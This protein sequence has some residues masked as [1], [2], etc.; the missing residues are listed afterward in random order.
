MELTRS[1][2]EREAEAYAR[3]APLYPV[4]RERVETLPDAFRAGEFG[5][6]DAEWVVRWYYRRSPGSVPDDERRRRERR[7]RRNEAETL[8][9]TVDAVVAT[10]DARERVASLTDLDGVDVPVASAFL[11]FLDPGTS[12]VVGP[13]EWNV[14]RDAGFLDGPYPDPPPVPAYVAYLEAARTLTDRFE[15]DAWTLYRALRRLGTDR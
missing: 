9:R 8:R 4:E 12:L 3:E 14:L 10:S 15:C 7:F 1:L 5:W 2:V 6:R 11:L 13:D